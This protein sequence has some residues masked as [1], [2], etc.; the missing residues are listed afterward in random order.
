[1][2]ANAS[3]VTITLDPAET[4]KGEVR[5]A[6]GRG[7]PIEDA[8]VVLYTE[9]GVRRS[10]TD[11]E[12][13]FSV[14]ELAAG[15]ARVRVRAAGYAPKEIALT[16]EALRGARPVALPRIELDREGSVEGVVVDARGDP[17]QGARVAKDRVPVYLKVGMPPAAVAVTD[18][19]GHFHLG[20]LAEGTCA[21][22][23]NAPDL[24]RT[25]TVARVTAGR[26]TDL[27]KITVARDAE[28]QPEQTSR[29][30]VAVTLGETSDHEVV[31]AAVTDSSEAER[32]G[33]APGDVLVEVDGTEVHTIEAARAKLGGPLGDD[34]L[35]KLRRG[36]TVST[37]RVPRE[38]V[39]R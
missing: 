37:L 19:R 16:I 15:A 32:A 6:R 22:D 9:M 39:R 30:G 26:E 11:R 18:A 33:L 23:V 5:A 29:G 20:E 13:A 8:E 38:E 14:G 35:L 7:E 25:R 10:R 12:G 24:G 1:V 4:A 2:D 27:G 34:V 28:R 21:L 36:D 17:V 3:S 31:L